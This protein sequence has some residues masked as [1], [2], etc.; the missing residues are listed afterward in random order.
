MTATIVQNDAN[1]AP[2]PDPPTT[3][4]VNEPAAPMEGV[5][6]NTIFTFATTIQF[7]DSKADETGTN[8]TTT[9][10]NKF[11]E[12]LSTLVRKTNNELEVVSRQSTPIK[13]TTLPSTEAD[14]RT[15][16]EYEV[17]KT[18]R[19]NVSILVYIKT[20]LTFRDLKHLML[21]WLQKKNI[22]MQR[23]LFQT[24]QTNVARTGFMTSKA[25]QDTFRDSFKAY[26]ETEM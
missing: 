18:N 22:F 13:L 11:K 4:P 25:P 10:G 17:F 21:D 20:H 2:A 24:K 15:L 12:W 5:E 19:R 6:T 9:I 26:I 1:T 3:N 23:H 8:T 14:V 16:L 7:Y